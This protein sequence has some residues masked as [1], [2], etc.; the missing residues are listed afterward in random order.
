M[1]D[2]YRGGE[3]PVKH[4]EK[5]QDQIVYQISA[6]D[7]DAIFQP[8]RLPSPFQTARQHPEDGNS[9]GII[10]ADEIIRRMTGQALTLETPYSVGAAELRAQELEK[11]RAFLPDT[12]P[13]KQAFITRNSAKV[14]SPASGGSDGGAA[15][16]AASECRQQTTCT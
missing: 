3:F 2:P 14:A 10:T 7:H 5:L 15:A 6:Q 1:H 9:C 8:E 11:I 16:A 4:E 13:R 12:D